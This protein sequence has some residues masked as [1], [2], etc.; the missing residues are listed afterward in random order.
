MRRTR[1][2]IAT[3]SMA[4]SAIVLGM[5]AATAASLSHTAGTAQVTV[6]SD[7]DNNQGNREDRHHRKFRVKRRH[8]LRW[9]HRCGPGWDSGWVRGTD[10]DRF[11]DKDHDFRDKEEKHRRDRDRDFRD[12]GDRGWGRGWIST[13]DWRR[14]KPHEEREGR[15]RTSYAAPSGAV[16]AGEGGSVTNLS[17]PE[18]AAGGSLAALGLVGAVGAMRRRSSS[19]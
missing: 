9:H 18:L 2:T 3:L 15:E 14:G 5:P 8:H 4:A 10:R 6:K 17:T 7:D 12:N 11:K 16:R 1:L 19:H 13:C